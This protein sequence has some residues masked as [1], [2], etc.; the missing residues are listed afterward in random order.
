MRRKLHYLN[1]FRSSH[2]RKLDFVENEF[3]IPA[4]YQ[5]GKGGNEHDGLVQFP[6]LPHLLHGLLRIIAVLADKCGSNGNFVTIHIY[7]LVDRAPGDR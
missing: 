7:K 2:R 4:H 5:V 6:H 1:V 3:I